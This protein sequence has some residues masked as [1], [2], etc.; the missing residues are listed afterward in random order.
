[1]RVVLFDWAPSPFCLKVRAILDY[2]GIPYERVSVLGPR[3]FEVRRRGRIGK[4]PALDV[5]GRFIVNSTGIAH[6]RERLFPSPSILPSDP[7]QRALDHALEDWA[8]EALYFIGLHYQWLGDAGAP[9]V[10]AGFGQTALR[11]DAY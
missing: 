3:M 4:V 10:A 6:E 9:M 7:R 5:D 8:D 1:M 2:K 11:A